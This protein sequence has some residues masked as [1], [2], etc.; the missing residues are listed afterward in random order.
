MN[1]LT[2]FNP[3][4]F[5]VAVGLL[6]AVFSGI[7]KGEYRMAFFNA[8]VAIAYVALAGSGEG[9]TPN[10]LISL[11]AFA[12]LFV[13]V[14]VLVAFASTEAIKHAIANWNWFLI[15]TATVQFL[16]SVSEFSRHNY[17]LAVFNAMFVFADCIL[18]GV[19][20]I[21]WQRPYE[22]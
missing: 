12:Y 13:G 16:A 17:F 18:A 10:L 11:Q 4:T 22:H 7:K 15:W 8:F 5:G 9:Q 20:N 6:G 21:P 1:Y 14:L 3:W 2:H 19:G